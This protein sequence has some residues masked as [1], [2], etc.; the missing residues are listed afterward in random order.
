MAD[1]TILTHDA[2]WKGLAPTVKRAVEAALEVKHA[3]SRKRVGNKKKSLNVSADGHKN[4][5]VTILLTDNAE[6][7]A[8]NAQYRGKN[9]PTNVLSFPDGSEEMGRNGKPLM[10]LGDIAMAY[11][12][13]AGEAAEQGKALKHHIA[14][15]TIHGVLHL[16]GYDH[17]EAGEA[18]AMEAQ[19]IA[20]LACMGIANPYESD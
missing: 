10:H 13:I 19:E 16:L 17:E 15:L 9:K 5:A 1:I 11:E 7:K 3:S 2:R 18:E 12:T 4:S 6:V 14:H 8:L 20:I